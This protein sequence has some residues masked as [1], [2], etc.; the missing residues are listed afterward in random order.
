[1]EEVRGFV[2][3]KPLREEILEAVDRLYF[4]NL[5][6]LNELPI[7]VIVEGGRNFKRLVVVL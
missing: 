5:F 6:V 4:H 2:D 3:I 1:M 7:L